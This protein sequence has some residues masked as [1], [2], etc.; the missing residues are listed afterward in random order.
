MWVG[1]LAGPFWSSLAGHD[2]D[3]VFGS[4]FGSRSEPQ[5]RPVLAP[6]PCSFVWHLWIRVKQI[7]A[8]DPSCLKV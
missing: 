6:L 5:S 4:E 3:P 8:L 2:P 1:G 7:N